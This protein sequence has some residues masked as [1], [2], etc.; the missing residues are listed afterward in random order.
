[1]R[2][3]IITPGDR[4]NRVVIISITQDF[5]PRKVLG[6]CDCGNEKEFYLKSLRAGDTTSCGCKRVEIARDRN[7]L[8]MTMAKEI[9]DEYSQDKTT[10]RKLGRKYGVSRTTICNI[11]NNK[12]WSDNVKCD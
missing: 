8:S 1:M 7:K 9:R 5:T 11:V 2:P 12:S 10:C 6:K 3:I 4:Y